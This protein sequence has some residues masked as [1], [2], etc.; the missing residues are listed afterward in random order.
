M[1]RH[2]RPAGPLRPDRSTAVT[3]PTTT[4]LL[5]AQQLGRRHPSGDGWLI[6]DVSLTIEGGQSWAIRG[7]SGAGKSV[8]LRS[9]AMLDSCDEGS[10]LW[11]HDPI[12]PSQVPW[13]RSRV[14]Y[15]AQTPQLF[16]GSVL[17]NLRMPFELHVHARRSYDSNTIEAMLRRIERSKTFL[18]AEADSLSGGERQLVAVMRAIQLEPQILLLDEPTSALD[19]RAAAAV[20]QLIAGWMQASPDDRAAVWVTH[21]AT[22]SGRIAQRFLDLDQGRVTGESTTP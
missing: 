17:D 5:T 15:V 12:G 9:L 14:M 11:K 3:D 4:H 7:P 22:Q 1:P 2:F 6:R 16:D 10:L 8:L 19:P 20:E 13:F 18:A 21:D